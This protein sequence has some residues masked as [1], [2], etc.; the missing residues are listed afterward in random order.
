[1]LRTLLLF[2]ISAAPLF[3]QG[4]TAFP[5]KAGRVVFLGDSIT[6]AGGYIA[7]LEAE[8]VARGV[9][10]RPELIN[11][12]LPSETCSGLSEPRHPFPRPDVH[13][14][15][16]RALARAKPDVVV[17]CYGMNDGIYYPFGEDRFER[18]KEGIEKIEVKV[19]AAGAKLVLMTPTVFDPPPTK[20]NKNMLPLGEKEY[21]WVNPYKDYDKDVLA[22][23]GEWILTRSKSADMVVNL[24]KPLLASLEA[25]RAKEPMFVFAGDAVHIN[26]DGHAMVAKAIANTWGLKGELQAKKELVSLVRKKQGLMHNSWLSHVGHRRPGMKAGLPLAKAEEKALELDKKI[27]ELMK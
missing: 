8:L 25:K 15:L 7:Y 20:P 16:E 3:A 26:D 10:P 23:Y 22:K 21:S 2:S 6:H 4:Q 1:M 27:A 24:R 17:A 11:L 5:L 14:R 12:G 13:E 9:S 19:R 18:Y